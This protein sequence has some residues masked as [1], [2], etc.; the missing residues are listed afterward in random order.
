MQ[1]QQNLTW[2]RVARNTDY[3]TDG[4]R[5]YRIAFDGRVFVAE[6][7]LIRRR[8]VLSRSEFTRKVAAQDFCAA[9]AS[10]LARQVFLETILANAFDAA[11]RTTFTKRHAARHILAELQ[12]AGF[13]FSFKGG[14]ATA[15]VTEVEQAS[16]AASA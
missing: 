15:D 2:S 13:E 9:F 8:D 10:N 1:T 6:V 3:A 5:A 12:R 11:A 7:S 14:L 4:V 16:E